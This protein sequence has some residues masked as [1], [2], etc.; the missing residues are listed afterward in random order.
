MQTIKT[1]EELEHLY[2]DSIPVAQAKVADHLT[3]LYR[4][5]IEASRFVVLSSVG[6]DGTDGSPRG[7]VES[8]VRIIDGKTIWLPDWRGN[9]R[10]DSLRNIVRDGRVSL[11]FMVPGCNNVV[12]INGTAVVT[13]DDDVTRTFEKKRVRPRTVI[14]LAVREVYFQCA[15][16]LMRS[17]LWESA[18]ESERV[19]SA[20]QIIREA[21]GN[22]D[23]EAY[24]S[25]YAT[26]AKDKLW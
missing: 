10:L 17:G 15:K 7:D 23:A 8:V 21:M 13:S 22:F 9:N 11:M 26:Y 19:P 25:G 12:R 14:V 6:P 20:G 5:W 1:T 3:P 4:R 24:D 18:D 2:G 16:A